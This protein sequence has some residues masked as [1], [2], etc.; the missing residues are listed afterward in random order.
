MLCHTG[1]RLY[2]A[3]RICADLLGYITPGSWAA[4]HSYTACSVEPK[5]KKIQLI[6]WETPEPLGILYYSFLIPKLA[7]TNSSLSLSLGEFMRYLW[8]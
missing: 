7:V 4:L 3:L 2:E 1:I 6:R 8:M 5:V